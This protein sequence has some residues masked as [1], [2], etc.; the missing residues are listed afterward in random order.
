MDRA[1]IG[2]YFYNYMVCSE[3][4][5]GYGLYH[6][7]CKLVFVYG[8]VLYF[9]RT[10]AEYD[11]MMEYCIYSSGKIYWLKISFQNPKAI[12]GTNFLVK[13]SLFSR[14]NP[15]A[16]DDTLC[17]MHTWIC[18][19]YHCACSTEETFDFLASLKRMLQNCQ[20]ILKNSFL[21]N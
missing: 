13:I 4:A 12:E 21:V 20:K 18:Q 10:V 5:T 15:F 19:T 9:Y 14:V 1:S 8:T 17:V 7:R 3:D 11:D 2:E 16:A 6:L